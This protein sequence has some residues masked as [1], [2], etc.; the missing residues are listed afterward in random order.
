MSG[1][2]IRVELA[3]PMALGRLQ[4]APTLDTV[5]CSLISGG[6][7]LT[8]REANE[9]LGELT[10]CVNVVDGTP[11]ASCLWPTGEIWR[12]NHTF[13]RSSV[14]YD[15]NGSCGLGRV[16]EVRGPWLKKMAT[17]PTV[18]S[19]TWEWWADGDAERIDG[20]LERLQSIGAKRAHGFGAVSSLRVYKASK[21]PLWLVHGIDNLVL[22]RP[23]QLDKLDAWLGGAKCSR[24]D[25]DWGRHA[26]VPLPAWPTQPWGPGEDV[27]TVVP[28]LPLPVA[29]DQEEGQ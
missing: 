2:R 11:L 23:V 29:H 4:Y 22:S 27:P 16:D 14:A 1:V 24:A 17:R 8:G 9:M 12:H 3:S 26:I 7:Q 21:Q 13:V 6:Q 18:Y 25:L 28:L 15:L 19:Q 10:K 20:W 5:L